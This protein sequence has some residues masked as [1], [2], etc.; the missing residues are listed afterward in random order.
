MRLFVY[1]TLMPG[2]ERWP[3]L[4]PFATRWARAAAGGRLWDSGQGY[5]VAR[6]EPAAGPRIPGYL[7]TL[8]EGRRSQALALLDRIEEVE[9][10]YRRVEVATSG[11]PAWA[12]EWLGP[13]DGLQELHGGWAAGGQS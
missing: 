13:T 10:L 9:V 8:D 5:P 7:V 3:V 12:Y 11:G 4:A 1:G 2:E 6:F